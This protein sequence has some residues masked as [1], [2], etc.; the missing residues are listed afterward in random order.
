MPIVHVNGVDLHYEEMG[1]GPDLL[2]AHGLLGSVEMLRLFGD[3][4]A[5]IARRGVHVV[6]YDARGH[7]RSGYTRDWHDYTW[8]ALASDMHALMRALRIDRASVYGGSMGAGTA[9]VLALD[10]PEAVERLI[11]RSPPPT[12]EH[13][14]RVRGMFAGLAM[15]FRLFGA[16]LT[17]RI[18][19][20]LPGRRDPEFDV[21]SF[22][23]AQR[24]AAIVPAIRGVLLEGLPLP[25]HRFGEI[26]QPALVLT[27]PGDAVHPLAAGEMLHGRMPHAR[28]AVAPT[29]SYWAE[30]PDALA[31]VV[32]AFARGE[33]V[34][35]GLPPERH[36]H[37]D[38]H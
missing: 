3:D 25:T 9:L 32:A 29:R 19:A 30:R 15:L 37:A 10:H 36:A 26:R 13:L 31:H 6:A 33:P 18:V 34:A 12:G 27:H 14:R 5:A 17:G 38:A 24:G 1:A 21:A 22:L 35:Q 11:L 2:V 4:I 7:G 23:G 8:R 16:R 28:L 20:R